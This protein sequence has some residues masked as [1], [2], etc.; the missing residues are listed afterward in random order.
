MADVIWGNGS[1]VLSKNSFLLNVTHRKDA[2]NNIYSDSEKIII[3]E[4]DLP[5]LP[6][7]QSLWN[8]EIL[9]SCVSE[10]FLKCEI[11]R[12]DKTELFWE[13]CHIQE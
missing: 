4:A 8:E 6:I 1:Q 3:E 2:N 5:G 7:D 9:K 12:R 13:K 10:A 11:N